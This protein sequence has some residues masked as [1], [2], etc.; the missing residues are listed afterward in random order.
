MM[1]D[2]NPE[3]D[4]ACS[5]AYRLWRFLCLQASTELVK[6]E[7]TL[8][9][10]WLELKLEAPETYAEKCGMETGGRNDERS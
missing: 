9:N 6:R 2:F 8:L 3:N 7:Q 5:S 4:L 10:H 1:T